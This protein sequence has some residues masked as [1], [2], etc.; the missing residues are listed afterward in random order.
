VSDAIR[1]RIENAEAALEHTDVFKAAGLVAD[2]R[3][4]H[5]SVST[6]RAWLACVLR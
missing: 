4:L 3:T 6:V 1:E 5:G 2:A